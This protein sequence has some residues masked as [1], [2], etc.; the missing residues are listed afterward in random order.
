MKIHTAKGV[1]VPRED[2]F[3]LE[4]VV[5][6]FCKENKPKA[7]LDVGTGTGIQ[8]IAAK[9]SGAQEVTAVDINPSAVKLVKKNAE[10]NGVEV[11]AFQSDL[12]SNVKE[13]FDLIIFNAPYLPLDPPI[14]PQWSGGR[15]LI[16][17]F[18]ENAKRH[19]NSG[20]KLLFVYS[21]KSPIKTKH[22]I[23]AENTMSD[24]EIVYVATLK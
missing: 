6:K 24:G 5:R 7:V 2:S 1:Y 16:E 15:K 19:V 14:D 20:G 8:A 21:S 11:R 22:K 13:S 4:K 18:V 3:L 9:L 17:K 12:F 10:R 23:L